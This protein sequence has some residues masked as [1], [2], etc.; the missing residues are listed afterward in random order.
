MSATVVVLAAAAFVVAPL[1]ERKM[2]NT[3]WQSV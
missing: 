1:I 2:T 3:I